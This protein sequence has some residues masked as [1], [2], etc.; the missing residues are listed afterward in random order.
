MYVICWNVYMQPLC[1]LCASATEVIG[2]TVDTLTFAVYCCQ[3]V[4][5]SQ[6]LK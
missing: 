3:Y 4:Q 6:L 2:N 5:Y 1:L